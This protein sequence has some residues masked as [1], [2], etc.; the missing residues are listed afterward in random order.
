MR[1]ILIQ[2]FRIQLF[3]YGTNNII[4]WTPK[5]SINPLSHYQGPVQL[6]QVWV[7]FR[8]TVLKAAE[9]WCWLVDILGLTVI[10]WEGG[11]GFL[12]F[13]MENNVVALLK[14][15][16]TILDSYSICQRALLCFSK[17]ITCQCLFDNSELWCGKARWHSSVHWRLWCITGC[18][19]VGGWFYF[20]KKKGGLTHLFIVQDTKS[21][22]IPIL[23]RL[24][25]ASTL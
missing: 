13:T 4:F 22:T 2:H 11:L 14:T 6:R 21:S 5:P 3:W 25:N 9:C 19:K 16:N 8:V 1:G 15:Q 23:K 17:Y 12:F 10:A 20:F 18:Q 24:R 7:M